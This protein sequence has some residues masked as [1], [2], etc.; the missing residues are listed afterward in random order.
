MMYILYAHVIFHLC[1]LLHRPEGS[2]TRSN[3]T[4]PSEK[5]FC[6]RML[7][8]LHHRFPVDVFR[9]RGRYVDEDFDLDLTYIT[10]RIIGECIVYVE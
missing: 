6:I 9:G 4:L 8:T 5:L 7:T 3:V 2:R 10:E 1:R